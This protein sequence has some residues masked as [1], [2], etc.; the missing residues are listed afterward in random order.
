[1]VRRLFPVLAVMGC[2]DAFPGPAAGR[3]DAGDVL[4]DGGAMG[5]DAGTHDSGVD[6]G[7][8]DGGDAGGGTTDAGGRDDAGAADAGSP[9]DAGL[10]TV[11]FTPSSAALPNPERGWYVWASG[12][13]GASIDTGALTTAYGTGVRLAYTVVDLSAFR[14]ASLSTP[15]LDALSNRFG[16]LR[17]LGMKA[18]VR[19][20][21]D[22]S[23]AGNDA[24]AMQIVAHL[25]QL[26]PLLAANEDTIAVFQAGFIGAWGEWHSS[27]NSNSY[28][29]MTNPGVTELQADANRLLVRNAVLAAVPASIPI[30]FRYPGDLIKW[31]PQATQQS[32]A[33]LHNDCWLAGPTDTG[34][35]SSQA[36]RTYVAAL[37][38]NATFGGE[39]CDADTPLRTSCADVR[40]EGAQYHLS[41]L[42]R[43]FFAGFI[44]AW[45]NG[46]CLDEVT[47]QM[48]YRL[49]LDEVSHVASAPAGSTVRVTV[50][51][52]N[53]GWAKL[54]S[55]RPLVVRLTQGNQALVASSTTLLSSL[56][57]QANG[58][59][60]LVIDVAIPANATRGTYDVSLAAPDVFPRTMTDARFAIR[61]A[62]A[63]AG[64]QAWS[65]PAARFATG[66]A[67]VIE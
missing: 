3:A 7:L 54:F 43:Q 47:R 9:P 6:A 42:N 30:A 50:K 17:S 18:V 46:G 44:T 16:T 51:L 66:T 63:D 53:V 58:S 14:S 45:T 28:G 57:A 10:V 20:A 31:W 67:L 19:F 34:T 27:K 49:Q 2:A 5:Q 33:G 25:Q 15:F 12:D 39:T 59:S 41:Y 60:T 22:Y 26:T 65:P 38:A 62:N 13:F 11:T 61:F 32:R 4:V 48:G 56:P 64:A 23:A 55:A 24:P 36:Q 29:Y 40:A 37:S 21:Y 35:Y 1:M 52:R 8:V